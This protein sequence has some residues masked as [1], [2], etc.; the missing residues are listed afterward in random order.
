M[1]ERWVLDI[2]DQCRVAW[3]AFFFK[4]WGGRNK[5]RAGRTLSGRTWDEIAKDVED[6][7]AEVAARGRELFCDIH[8]GRSK[9]TS[10]VHVTR[11]LH[12]GVLFEVVGR[13]EREPKL[14]PV[15]RARLTEAL[16]RH[17]ED[18]P[19]PLPFEEILR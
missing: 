8:G 12:G 16:A 18:V 3:V 13:K 14:A 10:E 17:R 5:K 6:D 15:S 9:S 1:D 11:P 2:Q 7:R 4:Q 19:H